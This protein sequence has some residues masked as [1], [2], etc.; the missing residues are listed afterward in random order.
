MAIQIEITPPPQGIYSWRIPYQLDRV[1]GSLHWIWNKV[2]QSWTLY[3]LDAQGGLLVGPL[4]LVPPDDLFAQWRHLPVP[5]GTLNVVGDPE[6]PGALDF[7]TNSRLIYTS[8][9]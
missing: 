7:G 6:R 2:H 8:I 3:L 1:S 4:S 9:G 5:P